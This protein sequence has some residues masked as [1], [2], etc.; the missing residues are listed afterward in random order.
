MMSHA[1]IGYFQLVCSMCIGFIFSTTDSH[2]IS[3]VNE[4]CQILVVLTG[5]NNIDLVLTWRRTESEVIFHLT[6]YPWTEN[7]KLKTSIWNLID[8]IWSQFIE[9]SP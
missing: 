9:P 5:W 8:N 7:C 3:Q 2:G 4:W 1:S 6:D